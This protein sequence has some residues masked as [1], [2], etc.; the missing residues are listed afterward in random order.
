VHSRARVPVISAHALRHTAA[1]LL[2]NERGANLRDVH[3]LLGHKSLATIARYARS[4]QKGDHLKLLKTK[5]GWLGF[6]RLASQ[7]S[8]V[9][10]PL[11]RGCPF[12]VP[13]QDWFDIDPTNDHIADAG[14]LTLA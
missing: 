12:A 8:L 5:T 9:A 13:H 4:W 11:T 7:R 14:Y 2:L 1:T 10:M 3:T 6:H